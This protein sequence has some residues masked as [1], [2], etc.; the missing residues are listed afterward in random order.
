MLEGI[1][2]KDMMDPPNLQTLLNPRSIAV[3]GAT[4]NK[5]RWGHHFKDL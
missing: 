1:Q 2:L 3:I 5:G 4:G